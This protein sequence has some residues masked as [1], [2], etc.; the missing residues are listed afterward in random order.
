M[1]NS[2]GTGYQGACFTY[3]RYPCSPSIALTLLTLYKPLYKPVSNRF[4]GRDLE[5]EDR[6]PDGL[7]PQRRRAATGR[8]SD[9]DARDDGS[10]SESSPRAPLATTRRQAYTGSAVKAKPLDRGDGMLYGSIEYSSKSQV[11]A[12]SVS[13]R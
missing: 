13:S 5:K 2:Y 10:D 7:V 4:H 12:L 9:D 3:I 8:A 1:N 11:L 6:R